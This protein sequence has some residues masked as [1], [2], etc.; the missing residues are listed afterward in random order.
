[1]RAGRPRWGR[2]GTGNQFIKGPAAP[3]A[4]PLPLSSFCIEA[5]S[6]LGQLNTL[7]FDIQGIV[8]SS[9]LFDLPSLVSR[10]IPGSVR[11]RLS[12]FGFVV[13]HL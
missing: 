4:L 1:M 8:I 13:H 12:S 9:Q 6:V 2:E 5:F 7:C 10:E 11:L 3:C